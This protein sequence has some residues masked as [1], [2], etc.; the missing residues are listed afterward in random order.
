MNLHKSKLI[1]LVLN[2]T[3]MLL[4]VGVVSLPAFSFG[5]VSFNGK[6]PTT[7]GATV[8][9]STTHRSVKPEFI[10]PI[11]RVTSIKVGET[12]EAKESSETTQST[13]SN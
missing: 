13:E 6:E 11:Q 2:S 1:K 9:S 8:L 7:N 5:I 10:E 4:L 3:L 12:L